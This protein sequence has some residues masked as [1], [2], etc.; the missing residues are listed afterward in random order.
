[1]SSRP[2][3][4]S[5][6]HPANC[7][8][9]GTSVGHSQGMMGHGTM[10]VIAEMS[11]L[12]SWVWCQGE[13]LGHP[14]CSWEFCIQLHDMFA[15]DKRMI[16]FPQKSASKPKV[17]GILV[18]LLSCYLRT[19]AWKA[20]AAPSPAGTLVKGSVACSL[21]PGAS[22]ST[23]L[24]VSKGKSLYIIQCVIIGSVKIV[25][26][27]LAQDIEQRRWQVSKLNYC[28]FTVFFHRKKTRKSH[29]METVH[30][31]WSTCSQL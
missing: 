3:T 6:C 29:K 18:M 8:P 1:M 19:G 13:V 4:S 28:H 17:S 2:P 30:V 14:K 7:T 9:V 20:Q 31:S 24:G 11:P 25:C 10:A 22:S 23:S 26:T 12:G 15:A 5:H 21:W 27:K 16:I